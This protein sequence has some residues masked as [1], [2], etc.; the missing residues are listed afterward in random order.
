MLRARRRVL[1]AASALALGALAARALA[2][3][4][5][6]LYSDEAYYWLWSLRPAPGYFDHPPLVAWLIAASS[7][8]LPG[9]LGVRLPFLVA[10]AAT[11]VF[12]ALLAGELSEDRRAPLLA[13]LLAATQPMMSLLGGLALPDAPAAA[14]YTAALWLF[15]RARRWRWLAAGAAVG[16]ALLAKYTAALLAP[17]LLLLVLW[18]RELRRDLRQ[19]WPW[20]A[21]LLAVAIF[22][23]CLAWNARHDFV[24]IAF[25]LGHGFGAGATPRSVLEFA[26][27]QLAGAG[28]VPLVLGGL[29]LLRARTSAARRVAVAVLLPLAVCAAAALRGRVEANWPALVYPALAAAAGAA[30]APARPLARGALVGGSVALGV[31][32]LAL[33]GAEQAHPQLLAGTPAVERFHGWRALA[34]EARRLAAGPCAA[35]GCPEGQPF[36]FTTNY[37]YAAELAFYGGFRRLGPAVE[38]RSQLDLWDDRPAPGEPFLYVGLDGVSPAF[39]AAFGGA[40]EQPTQRASIALAGVHLRDLTVTPFARFGGEAL[41]R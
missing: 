7:P 17:A 5:T 10:G 16:L 9:E 1:L 37:Q 21:A 40:G 27:G 20:L 32:L 26:L 24:S 29:A 34:D 33:F 18:D 28:P 11:V 36:L 41:E 22:A 4:P 25:Q 19:A 35:L 30:L 39:R 38:R 15:A 13:A 31:A 8:L 6:E 2:F 23:P 3:A 14:A 12:A